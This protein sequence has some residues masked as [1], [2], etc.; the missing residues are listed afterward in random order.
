[1]KKPDC[2]RFVL[3]LVM[4]SVLWTSASQ[5]FFCFSMGGGN[6]HRDNYYPV[7]PPY[8][9]FGASGMPVMPYSPVMSQPTLTPLTPLTPIAPVETWNPDYP[10]EAKPVPQQHIFH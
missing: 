9:V 4:S 10:V 2:R 1:M 8:G 5:A 6:R 3:F 7:P